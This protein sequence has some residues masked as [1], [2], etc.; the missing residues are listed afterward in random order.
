MLVAPHTSWVK[1]LTFHLKCCKILI[2][3]PICASGPPHI[4]NKSLVIS[5]DMLQNTQ[6][7]SAF[8]RHRFGSPVLSFNYSRCAGSL[9]LRALVWV[10]RYVPLCSSV[11]RRVACL[12][13]VW[14]FGRLVCPRMSC[15]VVC[16]SSCVKC[17]VCGLET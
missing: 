8:F 1:I 7:L 2:S 16:V 17:L 14:S 3:T 4:M 11:L 10:C 6:F 13:V 12:V 9:G 5:I 15:C